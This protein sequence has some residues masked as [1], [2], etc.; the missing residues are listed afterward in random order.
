VRV[1]HRSRPFGPARPGHAATGSPSGRAGRVVPLVLALAVTACTSPALRPIASATPSLGGEPSSPS[2]TTNPSRSAIPSRTAIPTPQAS[3][4]AE[5]LARLS[6]AQRIGQLL[7]VGLPNDQLDAAARNAIATVHVGSWWFTR[8][9][10]AGATAVHSVSA[11]IQ[12]QVADA[13]SG[14]IGFFIAANQEGGQIQALRGAGFDRIPSALVQGSWS[15]DTLRLR[16]TRWGRQLRSAG[17]NLDF[18]PVADVVTADGAAA[19]APIGALD[20]GYGFD[21]TTVA[22]HVTAFVAGMAAAGVMTTAKHFPGLGRVTQNTDLAGGVVDTVTT[23]GDPDLEPFRRAIEAGVP[24]VMVSLATYGAIDPSTIAAFSAPI[25]GGILRGDLGFHGLVMS[26]SLSAEAVADVSPADR[27]IRFIEAGGDLIVVRPI[28]LA[29]EM[30]RA[31]AER[32]DQ[33]SA[34]REQVDAAVLR[35]LAAKEAAGLLPCGG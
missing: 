13:S 3:C 2:P 22:D 21:P 1:L 6:E 24:A 32:V 25:V 10:T 20:R 35:V 33:Q 16:S 5:V 27:A 12:A 34:F 14:G 19:N 26:D 4:P 7:A 23:A 31:I 9:T 8:T 28:D 11:A 17:V 29:V 18:A 15:P 30:A